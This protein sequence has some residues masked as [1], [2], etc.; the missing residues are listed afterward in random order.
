MSLADRLNT[1]TES[2]ALWLQ[3][4]SIAIH[5]FT[6]IHERTPCQPTITTYF[7]PTDAV[8]TTATVTNTTAHSPLEDDT[9]VIPALI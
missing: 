2:K 4:V 8:N 7:Q 5:D 9:N 6:V 3:S 1:S